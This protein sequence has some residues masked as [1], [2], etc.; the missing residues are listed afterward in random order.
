MPQSGAE[1]P[2]P[3]LGRRGRRVAPVR[4]N[5]DAALSEPQSDET[6]LPQIWARA[7]FVCFYGHFRTVA[8]CGGDGEDRDPSRERTRVQELDIQMTGLVMNR[9]VQ[10]V[11]A[12]P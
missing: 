3:R 6:A 12:T 8:T 4:R 7:V 10:T 2:L 1:P 11:V 9:R 5:L